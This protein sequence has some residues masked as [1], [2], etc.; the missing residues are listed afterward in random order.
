[1]AKN[2]TKEYLLSNNFVIFKIWVWEYPTDDAHVDMYMDIGEEVRFRV[3]SETFVDTSPCSEPTSEPISAAPKTPLTTTATA[4][5]PAS[6][7]ATTT[8]DIVEH[9]EEK[10]IPYL[11]Q[12]SVNEPG[13]GLISWWNS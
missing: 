6:A 7:S 8:K 2:Y 11:I 3:T 9:Q 10:K 12:A 13:L 5:E 1:M 4:A